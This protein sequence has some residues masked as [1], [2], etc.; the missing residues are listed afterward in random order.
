[1]KAGRIAIWVATAVFIIMLFAP[2]MQQMLA[3]LRFPGGM[4]PP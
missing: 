3:R 4:G 2:L 1:M